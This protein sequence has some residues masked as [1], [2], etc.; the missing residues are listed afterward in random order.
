MLGSGQTPEWFAQ[1]RADTALCSLSRP[2][3]DSDFLDLMRRSGCRMVMIGIEAITDEALAEIGK[4]QHVDRVEKAVR[5]FHD[6]GIAVHGMF[7][8]GFDVDTATTAS[9]TAAFARRLRIDTFQLMVETP[10]PGTRLWERVSAEKRL[11]SADWS[12]FDG[13]YVVMRPALMTPLELQLGVLDTIRRFYSWPTIIASGVAGALRHLPTLVA[14]TRPALVRRLPT[15]TRLASARRW[16]EVASELNAALPCEVR[17]RVSSALWLP[18][19]RF[20]ARRQ[21]AAWIEQ[22]HSQKHLAF[23]ESLA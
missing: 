11:L 10:L 7:V 14:S 8:A 15:L 3:V 18:A 17:A 13:H 16:D 22:D 20:Y 4:R 21:L 19:L 23:L 1:V 5:A 2:D 12:L 6:H 9:E